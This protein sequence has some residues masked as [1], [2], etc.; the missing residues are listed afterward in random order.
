MKKIV[1]MGT[2]LFAVPILKSIYKKGYSIPLVYTQPPSKKNRGLEI[3]KS[4]IHIFC[5]EK[6]LNIRTPKNFDNLSEE[7]DILEQ[8]NADLAIV[9]AYGQMLPKSILNTC[10]K[11]F[12][13]I[14]ASLLPKWR[15][16]APIQR[17]I[18]NL[19][20][21]TGISVM[22]IN[23]KLDQGNVCSQF[24]ININKNDNAED[25][26]TKLSYLASQK[27]VGEIEEIFENKKTFFKQDH[28]K[29]TYA[30][31]IKKIEGKINWKDSAENI[32]GKI[33][34][35][36]P[37]PGAWFYFKGERYKILKANISN[38][39]S[40]PGKVINNNLEISC[41]KNSI[42]ILEIQ[43]EGKKVQNI[44]DF[45][46]GSIIRKGDELTDV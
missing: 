28:S 30:K 18:L 21:E 8:L 15:G 1:F 3:I 11:G 4:P 10:K 2:P 45:K 19:E 42:K 37:N 16:A 13:N 39:F 44:N 43:R 20:N 29:A 9:V 31:K 34:G 33:N 46:L 27:I 24:K 41:G 38:N 25:L 14:H 32:L 7:R 6:K 26:T 22:Q 36:Y 17:S 23:D 35:L 5:E 12:V 40:A